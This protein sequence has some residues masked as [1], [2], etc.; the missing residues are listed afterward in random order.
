MNVDSTIVAEKVLRVQPSDLLTPDQ[1]YLMANAADQPTGRAFL[2]ASRLYQ[3]AR[4]SATMGNPKLN[5]ERVSDDF[6]AQWGVIVGLG[7][8][9]CLVK[10]CREVVSEG[11]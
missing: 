3:A 8:A 2:T 11:S 7:F 1:V 9:D 5:T 6:R 10:A 4:L